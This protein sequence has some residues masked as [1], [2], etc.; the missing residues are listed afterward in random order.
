M[1]Y[2]LCTV[3]S[4][5]LFATNVVFSD[6]N[7]R[8]ECI[9]QANSDRDNSL[10]NSEDTFNTA[11]QTC[12]DNRAT[13]EFLCDYGYAMALVAIETRFIYSLSVCGASTAGGPGAAAACLAGALAENLIELGLAAA[14]YELCKSFIMP[15]YIDCTT[16]ASTEYSDRVATIRENHATAIA[17]C[18]TLPVCTCCDCD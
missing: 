10:G 6:F 7:P 18:A 4:V 14:G 3:L 2:K 8:Q 15:A 13:D 16:K 1:F 9:Y 12:R 11:M 5:F 17:H